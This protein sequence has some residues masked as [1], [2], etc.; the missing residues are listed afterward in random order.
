MQVQTIILIAIVLGITATLM[1]NLGKGVSKYG[2]KYMAERKERKKFYTFI[3]ILGIII[4]ALNVLPQYFG[5]DLGGAALISSLAGVG[6]VSIIIFSYFILDE[7]LDKII[8]TGIGVTIAGTVIV[9]IF[10]QEPSRL[11]INYINFWIILAAT[12]IPIIIAI[13]YTLTHDYV[14]FGFIFGTMAGIMSGLAVALMNM[15]QILYGGAENLFVNLLSPGN[16]ILYLAIVM[17]LGATVFTQ[18]GLTKGKASIVAPAYNSFYIIIPVISEV[19][20]FL[21][22]LSIFQIFGVIIIIIG[23]ILMTAFKKE[24]IDVI[25]SEGNSNIESS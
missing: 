19:L 4:T 24:P 25:K 7:I 18:Y 16:L 22:P 1:M 15:A 17:A 20:I 10:S 21:N 5:V 8:Y 23:V 6:L 14:F 3:W 11:H 2:L 13:I 12:L 9:G